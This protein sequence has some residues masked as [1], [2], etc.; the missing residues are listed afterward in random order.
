MSTDLSKEGVIEPLNP[1]LDYSE[2]SSDDDE[3][4]VSSP[5]EQSVIES[6]VTY[7]TD[8]ADHTTKS[9]DDDDDLE[10]CK[11]GD[12]ET[13]VEPSDEDED[14]DGDEDD[15]DA[16]DE[17]DH[18]ENEDADND[19]V[20]HEESSN[21][22]NRLLYA[23]LLIVMV[24][25]CWRPSESDDGIPICSRMPDPETKHNLQCPV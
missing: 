16:K 17:F 22:R 7:P 23:A 12:D 24:A 4:L 5:D 2:S 14:E 10:D 21:S 1:T 18:H 25:I 8:G 9:K 19:D 11:D 15:G 20:Q 6:N 13:F 3:D